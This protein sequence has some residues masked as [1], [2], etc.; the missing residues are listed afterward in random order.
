[1]TVQDRPCRCIDPAQRAA[2]DGDGPRYTYMNETRNETSRWPG[3]GTR[4]LV[5]ISSADVTSRMSHDRV[6]NPVAELSSS[7]TAAGSAPRH[8]TLDSGQI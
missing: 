4:P 8:R 5:A 7:T 6:P 1:M 3:S 2:L